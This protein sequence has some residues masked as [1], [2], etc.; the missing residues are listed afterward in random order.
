MRLQPTNLKSY[1]F[2]R[3]QVEEQRPGATP[4]QLAAATLS[5]M[6]QLREHEREERRQLRQDRLKVSR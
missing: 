3:G 2:W 5:F 4:A 6:R 1:R